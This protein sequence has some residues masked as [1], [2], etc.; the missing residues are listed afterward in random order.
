MPEPLVPKTAK[1]RGGV[2]AQVKSSPVT[3]GEGRWQR[4]S[5]NGQYLVHVFLRARR[6]AASGR[7]YLRVAEEE[8]ERHTQ[9]VAYDDSLRQLNLRIDHC[10]LQGRLPC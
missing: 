2:E 8:R 6:L 9:R 10:D 4:V 1:R 3:Q 5:K 7:L